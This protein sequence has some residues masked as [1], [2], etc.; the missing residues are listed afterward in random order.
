[1]SST[2]TS[3]PEDRPLSE[4]LQPGEGVR[5]KCTRNPMERLPNWRTTL[6]LAQTCP[7]CG[8]Q[9]RAK[10]PCLSPA[11][12]GRRRCRLHGGFSTGPR[13]AEGLARI[14]AAQTT[15]GLRTAEMREL[16]RLMRLQ[17]RVLE[18]VK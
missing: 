8:A 9:T 13:T 12:K 11:M 14:R 18:L 6:P 15:H 10:T 17:R 16:R 7:R 4:I 2:F 1:V 3:I 5:T